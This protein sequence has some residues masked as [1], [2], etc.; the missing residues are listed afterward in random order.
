MRI[1]SLI[2]AL[3]LSSCAAEGEES[4]SEDTV[5]APEAGATPEIEPPSDTDISVSESGWL[6]VGNDGAVQ[7][8]FFDADGRYRDLRNGEPFAEGSWEQRPDGR[9]CFEP[10]SGRGDCWETDKADEN[11]EASATNG[12][13]KVVAIKQITYLAPPQE[14]E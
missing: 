12:D 11:G 13:G 10:D 7:T 4:S 5:A 3:A 14:E 8:T 2:V 1:L 6:T 9:V